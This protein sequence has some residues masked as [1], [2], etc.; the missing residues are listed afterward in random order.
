MK[1]FHMLIFTLGVDQNV[2]YEHN[3]KLIQIF[4]E[5]F[6][7]QVHEIGQRISQ[8]KGHDCILV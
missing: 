4:H 6:G 2:I 3:H 7:H 5:H 8:S 1:M